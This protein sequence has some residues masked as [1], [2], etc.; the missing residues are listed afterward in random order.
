M[1]W[2]EFDTYFI[3]TGIHVQYNNTCYQ[4]CWFHW[5]CLVISSHRIFYSIRINEVF[6]ELDRYT[7]IL[8]IYFHL[9]F[10]IVIEVCW[11]SKT[12]VLSEFQ[13]YVNSIKHR[14][15]ILSFLFMWIYSFQWYYKRNCL[16]SS[17]FFVFLNSK[18]PIQF[19]LSYIE[20]LE[21]KISFESR[22]S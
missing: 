9:S 10:N 22:L 13:Q 1:Y 2:H 3:I 4:I 5:H 19:S 16:K 21:I 8:M 20:W 18:S 7:I 12:P 14:Y 6:N 11:W 17:H 15:F